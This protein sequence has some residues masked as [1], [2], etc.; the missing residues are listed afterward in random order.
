MTLVA[1]LREIQ[2]SGTQGLN[3]YD[4]NRP[5]MMDGSLSE[6]VTQALNLAY[7]KKNFTTGEPNFGEPNPDGNPPRGA[8]GVPNIFTPDSPLG[9]SIVRPSLEGMQQMQSAEIDAAAILL[10]EVVDANNR[11][12]ND[13]VMEKPIMVYT[14]PEDGK[15]TEEMNS[16]IDAYVDSGAVNLADF[17]FVYTDKSDSLMDD[18]VRVVDAAQK[19]KDYEGRG[20]R[21]YPSL[22]AFFADFDNLRKRH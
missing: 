3:R 5:V 4:P 13:H 7:S 18:G 21:S 9:E 14:I 6:T 12:E 19:L 16:N 1:Q 22:E 8:G 17:V 2:S 15:I 10:A 11:H 20:A